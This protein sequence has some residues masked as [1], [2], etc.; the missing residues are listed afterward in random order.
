MSIESYGPFFM[1]TVKCKFIANMDS[2]RLASRLE[3]FQSTA[4][5]EPRERHEAKRLAEQ[6][7]TAL[8]LTLTR[9]YIVSFDMWPGLP[10]L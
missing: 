4:V 8:I 5:T 1:K 3:E 10:S 9:N 6:I 2:A 7:D